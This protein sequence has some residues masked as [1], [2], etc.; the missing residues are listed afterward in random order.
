MVNVDT[1]GEQLAESIRQIIIDVLGILTPIVN[2][3]AISMIILG[4]L[5]ALAFRQEWL[6]YRLI[7][8]GGLALATVHLLIP[9]LLGFL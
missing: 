2:V 3:L 6:G 7:I 4:L 9:T 8:G 1:I 5:V